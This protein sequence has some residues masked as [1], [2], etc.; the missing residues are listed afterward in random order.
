MFWLAM[1]AGIGLL[2][3]V[4]MMIGTTIYLNRSPKRF[5]LFE[6][7][8]STRCEWYAS[9]RVDFFTA[10]YVI[11]HAAF[12]AVRMRGG[13]GSARARSHGSPLAPFLHID[14]NYRKLLD[15]CPEFVKWELI[16][17]AVIVASLALAVIGMGIDKNWWL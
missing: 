3:G 7:G 12:A 8:Y 16:K 2:I 6:L 4:L 11:S 13:W 15:E 17:I 14:G 5:R 1:I 10:N 9:G